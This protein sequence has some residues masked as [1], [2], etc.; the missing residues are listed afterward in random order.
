MT[1]I[2]IWQ[3]KGYYAVG[4]V[5]MSGSA[6]EKFKKFIPLPL[7]EGI[8]HSTLLSTIRPSRLLL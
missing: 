5:S 7:Q 4:Y 2:E 3:E 6:F 8:P 1:E